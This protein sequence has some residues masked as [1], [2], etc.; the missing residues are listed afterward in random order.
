MSQ[1][2]VN[3]RA[4]VSGAITQVMNTLRNLSFENSVGKNQGYQITIE[5]FTGGQRTNTQNNA[6]HLWCQLCADFL[7]A[8]GLD[9]RVV[10]NP[11]AEIPWSKTAFM[12]GVWR[13]VQQAQY[14]TTSTRQLGK[15]D[16]S[17]V[18][19]TIRRHLLNTKGVDLPP[20]PS[21]EQK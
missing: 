8:A 10:L 4:Q 2:F 9:Q 17:T 12:D 5:P 7:N 1:I 6:L 11:E 14:G 16:P 21:L 20:W 15:L 3:N 13:V 19:E 18:E